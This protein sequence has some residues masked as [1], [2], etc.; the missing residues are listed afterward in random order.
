MSTYTF[1]PERRELARQRALAQHAAG[2]QRDPS[3]EEIAER[4]AAIQATWSDAEERSR[5]PRPKHWSLEEL[6]CVDFCVG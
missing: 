5:R 4:C 6:R 1:T 2:R 3:A